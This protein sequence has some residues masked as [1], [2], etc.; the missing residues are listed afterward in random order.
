ME[1]IIKFDE[2]N[3]VIKKLK[4]ENQ[5]IVFTNGCFDIVHLGHLKLLEK[6]KEFGTV[7]VGLNSDSSIRKL[8]GKN[9]PINNIDY[10]IEFLSLLDFVDYIIV[11]DE[12]TPLNLIKQ[13]SPDYLIKGSDYLAENIVG[14]EHVISYGGKVLTFGFDVNQSTTNILKKLAPTA[15]VYDN[16]LTLRANT[17]DKLKNN[18]EFSNAINVSLNILRNCFANGNKVFIAGNGGSAEQANHFA[19]ELMG[20]FKNT[21][22]IFP[23]ISLFN[24]ISLLTSLSNDY[25]YDEVLSNSLVPLAQEGDCLFL[26][27]T[28][29]TSKNIIHAINTGLKYKLKIILLTS[30][31]VPK[32]IEALI[33]CCIKIPATQSDIIQEAHLFVIH[34]LSEVLKDE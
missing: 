17:Y 33:N 29:G 32:E 6:C 22:K 3:K 25:C 10:R 24:N 4:T 16:S 18:A 28:S 19:S 9:R 12:D 15:L 27:S 5:Q 31:E 30:I 13:I 21:T 2:I 20:H 1:K 14:Y 23:A 26:I 11:F 8:K 7:I 34:Y